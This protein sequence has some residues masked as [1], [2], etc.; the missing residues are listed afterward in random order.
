MLTQDG[1]KV[2]EFNCRF[3]DPE[4]EAILPLMKTSLL[5]LLDRVARGES[6][7]SALTP[8]WV[9]GAA[10]TT[11]IAAAGYPDTPK[12]GDV[13]TL[14][15]VPKG[16]TVFHAGTAMRGS[17]LISSGGRVL[18]VTGTGRNIHAA[19]ALSRQYAESVGLEGK[20]LRLDIGWREIGRAASA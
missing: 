14:P 1:P 20:Q 15:P 11:V 2:I 7:S 12:K 6:V 13:I 4:T 8:E 18:A 16:V 10:V 19:A 9:A 3:G 5:E 17:E